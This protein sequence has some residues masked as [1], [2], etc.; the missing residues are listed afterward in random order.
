VTRRC[1]CGSLQMWRGCRWVVGSSYVCVYVLYMYCLCV[2]C[3][4]YVC[5]SVCDGGIRMYRCMYRCMYGCLYGC[6]YGCLYSIYV[7]L[8]LL[9]DERD[10]VP[11][12]IT[13]VHSK[14]YSLSCNTILFLT[15]LSHHCCES[16]FRNQLQSFI[17]LLSYTRHVEAVNYWTMK[18]QTWYIASLITFWIWNDLDKYI[19]TIRTGLVITSCTF[20]KSKPVICTHVPSSSSHIFMHLNQIPLNLRL[21]FYPPKSY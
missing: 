9:Y 8:Q 3:V 7:S 4:L 13:Y 15:C 16:E 2:V 21:Q 12:W 14:W 5:L 17:Q 10:G 19:L 18:R 1:R 20:S 11:T 6:M